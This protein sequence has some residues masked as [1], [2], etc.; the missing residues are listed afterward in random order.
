MTWLDEQP[1]LGPGPNCS[2]PRPP[3]DDIVHAAI[4]FFLPMQILRISGECNY[5]VFTV[6][7]A[8]TDFEHN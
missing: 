8:G 6:H 4:R 5:N 3:I 1:S 2:W 7:A